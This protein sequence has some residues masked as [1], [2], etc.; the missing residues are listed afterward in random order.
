MSI[1]K[2][3]NNQITRSD[4]KNQLGDLSELMD[5]N[6]LAL[7]AFAELLGSC[8]NEVNT[9]NLFFLINPIIQHNMQLVKDMQSI[10]DRLV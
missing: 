5:N 1:E 4:A 6:N 8:N 2:P 9:E 7:E 3:R 10:S